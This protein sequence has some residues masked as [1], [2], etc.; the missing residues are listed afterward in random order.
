M[1]GGLHFW[2]TSASPDRKV[3]FTKGCCIWFRVW[4]RPLCYELWWNCFYIK[5]GRVLDVQSIG[6]KTPA[7]S[8]LTLP[9]SANARRLKSRHP[10]VTAAQ[11]LISSSDNNIYAALWADHRWDAGWL[12]DTTRLRTFI[13]PPKMILPRTAWRISS[14]SVGSA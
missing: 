1:Y 12:D 14:Q 3:V 5:T 11:H 6:C 10:F 4:L 9:S 7:H 8:A 13:H 2:T